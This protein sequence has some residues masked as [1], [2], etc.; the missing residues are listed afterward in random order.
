MKRPK[1]RQT[2]AALAGRWE[3][4]N[5]DNSAVFEVA[6]AD[7][8]PVVTGFDSMDGEHFNIS[9]VEWDG[10]SLTF[11]TYMPSSRFRSKHRFTLVRAGCVDHELTVIE[12][13]KKIR[14]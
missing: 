6:I 1:R 4:E 9:Q 12:R 5:R 8:K 14:T 13:W 11:A 10:K 3:T 2:L 7:E